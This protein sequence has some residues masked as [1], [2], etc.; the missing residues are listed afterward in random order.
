[1]E[2]RKEPFTTG[3]SRLLDTVAF[4]RLSMCERDVNSGAS[5]Q[6]FHPHPRGLTYFKQIEQTT[7]PWCPISLSKIVSFL[8][9]SL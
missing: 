4:T 8:L 1:M 6:V 7:R 2:N 5:P 3:I 9:I